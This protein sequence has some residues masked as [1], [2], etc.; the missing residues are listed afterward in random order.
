MNVLLA[1]AKIPY[2]IVYELEDINPRIDTY[3]VC[4]VLGANDIVNPDTSRPSSPIYGMPVLEVWKTKLCVVMK[5]GMATGYS[6]IENPLFYKPNTRM[7]FGDAKVSCDTLYQEV[8]KISK[9]TRAGPA[10][11][12]DASERLKAELAELT[13]NFPEPQKTLGFVRPKRDGETRVP[14]VPVA[15]PK[16]RQMGLGVVIKE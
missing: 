5:R 12:E 16:I 7:F 9:T 2:D 14:V 11:E 3:D 4:I 6:G 15:V 10:Q 8:Q 13:A 1:E